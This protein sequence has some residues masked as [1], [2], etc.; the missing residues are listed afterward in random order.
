MQVIITVGHFIGHYCQISHF[1]NIEFLDCAVESRIKRAIVL[2]EFGAFQ[3]HSNEFLPLR[4]RLDQTLHFTVIV[5]DLISILFSSA[6]LAA[7]FIFFVDTPRRDHARLQ[8][9]LNSSRIACPTVQTQTL[10]DWLRSRHSPYAL[11]H[12]HR[13]RWAP[14]LSLEATKTWRLSWS[15]RCEGSYTIIV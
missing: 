5:F 14:A 4:Q 1:V 11:R 13:S 9:F 15:L 10:S 3:F 8:I 7:I 2:L 12:W 6:S